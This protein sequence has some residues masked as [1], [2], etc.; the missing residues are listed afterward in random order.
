VKPGCRASVRAAYRRSCRIVSIGGLGI[1]TP[2]RQQWLGYDYFKRV[3]SMVAFGAC[4]SCT[5]MRS[6]LMYFRQPLQRSRGQSIWWTS[7]AREN[8]IR[9]SIRLSLN[10]FVREDGRFIPA[11]TECHL[12]RWHGGRLFLFFVRFCFRQMNDMATTRQHGLVNA[13]P[14]LTGHQG[15]TLT[16]LCKPRFPSKGYRNLDVDCA[17]SSS[18]FLFSAKRFYDI[19]SRSPR[20]RY[21]RCQNC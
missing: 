12:R 1:W 16:D 2:G 6:P 21:Q 18:R 17:L 14:L 13:T 9:C 3:A 5:T 10:G 7:W 19:D 20:G 8:G 15:S 4:P 11:N